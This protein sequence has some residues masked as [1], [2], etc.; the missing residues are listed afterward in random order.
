MVKVKLC[1]LKR[2]EDV[3]AVN[4]AQAE[5]AGFVFAK[6][7]RQV[8]PML[9]RALRRSL[10]DSVTPVGV[11][12]NS[13]VEETAAIA[14]WSGMKVVQLHG[15][16]DA[17]YVRTLRSLLPSDF[18]IWKAAHV[19][20]TADIETAAATGPDKLLLDAF[21]PSVA[22][23]TGEAFNWNVLKGCEMPLPFMLAGGL[24]PENVAE[25]VRRIRPYGVDVSSGVETDGVK[26]PEKMERFVL[27][28]HGAGQEE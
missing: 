15:D 9:A 14:Q 25:A 8:T 28:A 22:G 17:S 26:D 7:R 21:S 23:G 1:G 19:R 11:F 16:E 27:A 20:G 2:V 6:S 4:R 18:E 5:Y 24:M 13:P 10:N 12:V 3:F